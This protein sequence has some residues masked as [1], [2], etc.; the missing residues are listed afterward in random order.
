MWRALR[1]LWRGLVQFE[2]YSWLYIVCN[3]L[4]ALISIPIVTVPVAFAGLSRLSHT[5]QRSS[6]SDF[7]EFWSGVREHFWRG[8]LIGCLNVVIFVILWVNLRT[9]SS[10]TDPLVVILRAVWVT[11]LV[12]SPTLQFYLWPIL[13]EMD[14]PNLI[15]GLRN[16]A[17]MALQNI[18]FT[19]VLLIGLT[20]VVALSTVLF[21]PWLLL[22]GSLIACIANAAV[23]EQLDAFRRGGPE[24]P[25]NP[26]DEQEQY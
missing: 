20:V 15:D 23:I 4:A 9:Y 19:T 22:T 18:G 3:L 1:V 11:V 8:L 12:V 6:T 14:R 10:R 25:G 13:E 7:T 5:A 21:V 17:V 24:R 16:A 26:L 2:R